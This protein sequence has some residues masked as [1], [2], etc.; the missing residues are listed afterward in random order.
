MRVD[1]SLD[2]YKIF[3]M[4]VRV[5]NMSEAAKQLHISQPAVSMAMRQLE[6]K[7]GKPL[8][9]RSSKGIKTTEEGRILYE[10]L[11]QAL[12]LIEMAEKKYMQLVNLEIGEIKIGASDTIIRNYLI[13]HITDYTRKYP[14]IDLKF[15]NRTTF[16]TIDM[17]KN[18]KVDIGFVN[19]PVDPELNL[20]IIE[21][22]E[23][24]EC[25]IAGS[26]FSNLSKTGVSLAE[27]NNHPLMLLE[28]DSNSRR[29]ID[30]AIQSHGIVLKPKLEL[31]STELLIDFARINLGLALVSKEIAAKEI[32]NETIFEIPLKEKL[33][34]RAI[35]LAMLKGVV[36][37]QA[38]QSF[39]NLFQK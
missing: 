31:G 29:I 11:Q 7:L 16:D 2:L 5:K 9:I 8:L 20:E 37:S 34:S 14:E 24:H 21:F 28:N 6:E 36:L 26:K 25:V 32:D 33:P 15:V 4:V 10:Y 39:V 23:I 13:T 12:G 1:I 35:G 18:G 38:A 19:L 22:M 17:L 3:C 30:K 27:L